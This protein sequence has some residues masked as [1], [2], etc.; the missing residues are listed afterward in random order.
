MAQRGAR[1]VAPKPGVQGEIVHLGHHAVDLVGQ[2]VPLLGQLAAAG[3]H[4]FDPVTVRRR[5]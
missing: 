4:R 2:V 3:D 5:G 1:D